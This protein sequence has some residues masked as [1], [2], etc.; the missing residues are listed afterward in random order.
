MAPVDQKRMPL[1]LDNIQD[2]AG[3]GGVVI[4]PYLLVAHDLTISRENTKNTYPFG[5]Y[6]NEVRNVLF[7][8][9]RT[10]RERRQTT[11]AQ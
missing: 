2:S 4:F 11:T 1:I 10:S 9:T 8:Q 7:F 3:A 6:R 5:V